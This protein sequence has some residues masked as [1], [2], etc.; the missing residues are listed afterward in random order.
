MGISF[1]TGNYVLAGTSHTR[2]GIPPQDNVGSR[3]LQDRA[4]AALSDGS[5]CGGADIPGRTEI[6]SGLIVSG[7]LNALAKAKIGTNQSMVS[8]VR[9]KTSDVITMATCPETGF[10]LTQMDMMATSIWA[11]A[12]QGGAIVHLQGD[13][14]VAIRLKDGTLIMQKHEWEGSMPPYP[15]YAKDLFMDFVASH[16]G[17]INAERLKV[18][19]AVFP[20]MGNATFEEKMYPLRAGLQGR[21]ISLNRQFS[22]I[23]SFAI[24]SDGVTTIANPSGGDVLPWFEAV[25]LLM[26]FPLKTDGFVTRTCNHMTS[27]VWGKQGL[28][29]YDDF[30]MAAIALKEVQ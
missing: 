27:K 10:G 23:D 15:A 17:N 24:F 18:S 30:S 14:V 28:A 7:I 2:R 6:G 9:E 26:N 11:F 8:L 25:K 5:S 20:A 3:A 16:G 4:F 22:Q 19:R 12:H 29:P 1:L 21:T 13:G